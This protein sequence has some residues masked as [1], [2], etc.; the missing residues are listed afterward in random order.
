[1]GVI[2]NPLQYLCSLQ[3][4]EVKLNIG[5]RVGQCAG[6]WIDPEYFGP[7]I[8]DFFKDKPGVLWEYG[9]FSKEPP[10]SG[11]GEV[12][13][14]TLII[15]ESMV[16]GGADGLL[17][18]LER[19]ID[20]VATNHEVVQPEGEYAPASDLIPEALRTPPVELDLDAGRSKQAMEL[21]TTST[22]MPYNPPQIDGGNKTPAGY[23]TFGTSSKTPIE[24]S[25]QGRVVKRPS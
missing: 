22:R 16:V 10:S 4:D 11:G 12:I 5:L 3:D 20:F 19:W 18:D 6:L 25:H 13:A 8:V 23:G 2:K 14:V 7:L 17:R 9:Y 24:Y 15:N 21:P 1:M